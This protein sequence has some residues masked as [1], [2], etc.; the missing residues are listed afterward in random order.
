ML[1]PAL[2]YNADWSHC[3]IISCFSFCVGLCMPWF[4]NGFRIT[5]K[6]LCS[7]TWQK[8][9]VSPIFAHGALHLENLLPLHQQCFFET[10]FSWAFYRTWQLSRLTGVDTGY[11]ARIDF[12]FWHSIWKIRQKPTLVL[13]CDC[14]SA[15][16]FVNDLDRGWC[17]EA[18]PLIIGWNLGARLA[19]R[20]I[21]GLGRGG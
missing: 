3:S 13:L 12:S 16:T 6:R 21:Q 19:Q 14:A 1:R 8:E 15:G 20:T 17:E 7:Y 11:F 9:E 18:G 10:L 2:V 5:D 4:D